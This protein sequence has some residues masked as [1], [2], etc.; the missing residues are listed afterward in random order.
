MPVALVYNTLAFTQ[1]KFDF[2][3]SKH[4]HNYSFE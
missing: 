1:A 4:Y 3:T 2:D